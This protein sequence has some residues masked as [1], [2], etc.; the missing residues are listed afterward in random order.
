MLN[1]SSTFCLYSCLHPAIPTHQCE[2]MKVPYIFLCDLSLIPVELGCSNIC[3]AVGCLKT[4]VT[5]GAPNDW[6]NGFHSRTGSDL[7]VCDKKLVRAKMQGT[8]TSLPVRY[9]IL[10]SGRQSLAQPHLLN[11]Q[12]ATFLQAYLPLTD[13]FPQPLCPKSWETKN[14]LGRGAKGLTFNH[15]NF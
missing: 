13:S 11:C 3:K 1:G 2:D 15:W 10:C 6:W 4:W 5:D 12:C 9:W 8:G 7:M 14:F